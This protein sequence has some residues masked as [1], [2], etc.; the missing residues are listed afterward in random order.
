MAGFFQT[1]VESSSLGMTLHKS[2]L[3]LLS[4]SSAVIAANAYYAQPLL[5]YWAETFQVSESNAGQVFFLSMLGQALGM[6]ILIPLGDKWKRKRLI[7]WT[8]GIT[9]VT[10]IAAAAAVNITMLKACM[11]IAGFFSIAPQLMIPMA[12]DLSV[13]EARTHIVG[14]ITAGVLSGVVFARLLGGSVTEWISWRVVYG[15]S[16]LFLIVSFIFIYRYIPES[17]SKFEG[18]YKQIL[19][20]VWKLFRRYGEIRIAVVVSGCAFVLSRMFWAT[21]AFLLANNFGMNTGVIGLFGLVTLTGAFSAPLAG[22]LS[23]RFSAHQVILFG[24]ILLAISFLLL[25]F[26]SSVVILIIAGGILMEGSRQ[27]TQIT[28]QSQVISLVAG[29][30]SRLNMLYI[31]G[32][33]AGAALGAALGLIAWHWN[34]WEGVCYVA[35]AILTVQVVTYT[36]SLRR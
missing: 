36:F 13:K 16:A 28:M 2:Q 20:S 7:L 24:I 21:I 33:F 3:Y 27:L 31:S 1:F 8:I 17:R 18:S 4:F 19:Q 23:A 26:F 6:I 15:L 35:F 30:R 22:R 5:D 10:V 12:V 29:A 32:C 14:L 11:F 34:K 9:T 25:Y